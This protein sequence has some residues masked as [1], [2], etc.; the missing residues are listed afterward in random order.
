MVI[1]IYR[2]ISTIK[3]GAVLNQILSCALVLAI[4]LSASG[5]YGK[6]HNGGDSS[7]M[8]GSCSLSPADLDAAKAYLRFKEIKFSH[9]PRGVP[10]IY[11]KELKVSFDNAQDA[12]NKVKVLGP[13]YGNRKLVLEDRDLE[14]YVSIGSKIACQYCCGATTLVKPDGEAACGC[15]HS[16]MMRGL[17]AYLIKTHPEVSDERILDELNV[18]KRTFFPKQTLMAKLQTMKNK[19]NAG[20][21]E[22]MNE[23]P[24][25]LPKMVGGC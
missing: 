14:R 11:G 19:G 4:M 1:G 13:T 25:F 18:W 7:K 9:I 6:P 17:A 24:D 16:I 2:K 12:I 22:I 10:D 15:A 3:C 20:I 21:D 5:A 8:E 23:F